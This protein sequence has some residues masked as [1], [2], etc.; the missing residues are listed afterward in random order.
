MNIEE[1]KINSL[2]DEELIKIRKNER[3]AYFIG[4]MS[5]F[6]WGCNVV[7]MKT[8]IKYFPECYSDNSALFWRMLTIALIGFILCKYRKI[9]ILRF[10]EIKNKKWFLLRNATSY[11]YITCWI[12]MYSY[13][14]VSTISVIGS[15]APLLIIILS[16]LLIKEKFYIRYIYGVFICIL[17]AT[18]IIF[19]DQKPESKSQIINDN[20]FI[21]ILYSITNDSLYS[22]SAIGQKVLTEEGM[23]NDLQNYYFG[24]YNTVPAFIVFIISGEYKIINIKYI[25]YIGINGIILYLSIYLTIISLKY[26]AVSK[27]QPLTYLN[28]V[29]IFILSSIILGEPIF[30]TDVIGAF[31]I[32]GFQYYNLKYPV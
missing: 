20:I 2:I 15:T 26:I 10:S 27:F 28:V 5:Q 31:I 29:F 13:F 17:G 6:F 21:G 16:A 11:I 22:L 1:S 14:R 7:Q 18:I 19:N 23:D 3:F 4:I 9:N 24:L 8:F 25:L 30:F 12:K 32:I